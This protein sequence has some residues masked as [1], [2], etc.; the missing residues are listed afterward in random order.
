VSARF[1]AVFPTEVI[2]IPSIG[3]TIFKIGQGKFNEI[4]KVYDSGI[5]IFYI[6]GTSQSTTSV[7]YTGFVLKCI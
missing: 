4:K 3:Q 1:R 7:V 2:L 6:T 5:N